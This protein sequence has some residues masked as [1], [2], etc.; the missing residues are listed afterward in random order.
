MLV[1]PTF[2]IIEPHVAHRLPGT[3]GMR[4]VDRQF[5]RPVGRKNPG[6]VALRAL[7]EML[8]QVDDAPALHQA[9]EVADRRQIGKREEKHFVEVKSEKLKAKGKLNNN[10]FYTRSRKRPFA[11]KKLFT[12]HLSFFTLFSVS[13]HS[14]CSLI[15][16]I[17]RSRA[18]SCGMLRAMTSRPLYKVIR[19]G[20]APT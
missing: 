8:A 3:V 11:S 19:P 20:P 10:R 4:H 6:P 15:S 1:L 2:G 13:S 12:F 18:S 17:R 9:G 14:P 5:H 16:A 7:D